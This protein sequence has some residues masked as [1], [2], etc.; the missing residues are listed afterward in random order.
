M[1]VA[2]LEAGLDNYN[3]FLIGVVLLSFSKVYLHAYLKLI[4][5][6]GQQ[7]NFIGNPSYDW[8]FR[9]TPQLT[10]NNTVVL[11]PRGKVLGGTSSVNFFVRTV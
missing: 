8:F 11:W 10:S 1:T 2:V 4:A 6:P 7:G 9:T 5:A 3:D